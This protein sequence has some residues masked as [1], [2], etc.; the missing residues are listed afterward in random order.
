MHS[1]HWSDEKWKSIMAKGGGNKKR[2]QYCTDPPG[3]ILYL[4]ALPGHS[5]RNL[6]DPSLQDNVLIPNNFFEY[7]YHVGCAINS[8]SIINSWLIPGGQNLS[9]RQ[10]VFFLP[11]NGQRTQRSWDK[12]PES[13]AY[14]TIHADS[15]EETSK[16]GVLG[17]HQTC[18]KEK[19]KVLSD[20]IERNHPS[21]CTPSLL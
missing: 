5:R 2:F 10:T 6:I 14:C 7:I 8:H 17:R 1:R 11:V 3:E 18:S 19:I 15:V 21:Q 12:R 20:A 4:R 9:K 16:H 13:T